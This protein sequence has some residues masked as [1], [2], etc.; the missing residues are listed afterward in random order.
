MPDSTPSSTGTTPRPWVTL[1]FGGSSLQ[2]AACLA[3]VAKIITDTKTPHNRVAVICSAMG[4]TTNMLLELLSNVERTGEVDISAL[5]N[6]HI[7]IF[8]DIVGM[9]KDNRT[10]TNGGVGD[11]AGNVGACGSGGAAATQQQST[12]HGGGEPASKRQKTLSPEQKKQQP[13][14]ASCMSPRTWMSLDG[15]ELKKWLTSCI[16]PVF[17]ELEKILSGVSLLRHTRTLTGSISDL[18]VS[19][20]ERLSVKFVALVLEELYDCKARPFAA[21]DVGFVKNHPLASPRSPIEDDRDNGGSSLSHA[22]AANNDRDFD[23]EMIKLKIE[24]QCKHDTIP[25]ITGFIAKDSFGKI[26]TL[27]R[28]GSDLTASIVGAALHSQCVF[29]WKD[30]DGVLTSDP[31][32]V[33]NAVPVN[34]ITYKEAA[35]L[36]YFGAKVVH[37]SCIHPLVSAGIPMHVKNTLQPHLPGTKIVAGVHVAEFF[38]TQ[39]TPGEERTNKQPLVRAISSKR[40]VILLDVESSRM[41]YQSGFLA[42][43]FGLFERFQISVDMIASSDVSVSLTLD[44]GVDLERVKVRFRFWEPGGGQSS[45]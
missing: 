4:K 40:G 33:P 1:K 15:G 28:D 25:I 43:M 29:I 19:F 14:P 42:G 22:A 8:M 26:T 11:G 38:S 16:D 31:R 3:R 9:I 21:W 44:R 39:K 24:Q 2:D 27:G 45:N 20:G 6:K 18:V 36:A 35:E 13:S 37:P 34:L 23:Y 30:V 12:S 41:L 5:K 7:Q 32:L 17:Q 10:T